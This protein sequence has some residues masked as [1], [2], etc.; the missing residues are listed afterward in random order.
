MNHF[1]SGT[2]TF[3]FTDIEGSTKLAQEHPDQWENMRAPSFHPAIR[4]D[5]HHGYVFQIIGDAFCA[6]FHTASDGINAAIDAQHQFQNEMKGKHLLKVRMGIHTGEAEIRGNDYRG[7]LTLARVQRVMSAAHGGQI[8]LSNATAE[9]IR[10]RL[11]DNVNLRDMKEN[12]LKGWSPAEHLWQVVAMGLQQEFPPL[13]TLISTPNNLPIQ[14]TSFVG[15]EHEIT[16]MKQALAKTRLVT[17]TGSG[18]TGKTRLSV[19]VAAE[20][21]DRFKDGIAF[22]ELA[23]TTDP[24]LVPN[25]V[26]NALGVR[27]Q[28]RAPII[29]Y[30]GGL[31]TETENI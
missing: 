10:N 2:V 31:V 29:G 13:S 28:S 9:L 14:M 15:R 8:F 19:Q 25:T 12:R 21:L 7:Y 16:E 24:D 4:D 5:R 30:L 18:G 20:M 23:P 22:I 1:P 17:L 3:L 26:A 6:A 11:P 27:E